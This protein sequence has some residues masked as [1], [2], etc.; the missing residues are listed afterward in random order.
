[1]KNK[2][3]EILSA[4]FPIGIAKITN[5]RGFY[6][7]HIPL[8]PSQY[9]DEK[10]RLVLTGNQVIVIASAVGGFYGF[11]ETVAK[12]RDYKS[13]SWYETTVKKHFE[14]GKSAVK[15]AE[16]L[17]ANSKVFQVKSK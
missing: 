17:S 16:K 7:A 8:L 1:M 3:S 11:F 13:K 14:T 15:V 6:C 12:A 2:L 5:K 4:S 9:R 10:K